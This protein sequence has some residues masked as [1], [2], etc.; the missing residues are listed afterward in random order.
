[1]GS[2][3]WWISA[4][5]VKPLSKLNVK[6]CKTVLKEITIFFKL[7]LYFAFPSPVVCRIFTSAAT[8]R[9][10]NMLN[11]DL[12]I[13]VF[14]GLG[15]D[16]FF[17][18][19]GPNSLA[20]IKIQDPGWPAGEKRQKVKKNQGKGIFPSSFSPF[21]IRVRYLTETHSIFLFSYTIIIFHT[22]T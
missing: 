18:P 20:R 6:E 5:T 13:F 8:T 3:L 17:V 10:R 14:L 19:E 15:F 22:S 4:R 12:C 2:C 7:Q 21:P 11:R 16:S 1:M 9:L